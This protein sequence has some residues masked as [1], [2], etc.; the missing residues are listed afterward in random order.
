MRRQRLGEPGQINWVQWVVMAWLGVLL[1]LAAGAVLWFVFHLAVLALLVAV[2]LV[3]AGF[4]VTASRRWLRRRR[5]Q[6]QGREFVE[7]RRVQHCMD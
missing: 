2:P 3:A 6:L 4:V 1:L 7:V 5:A